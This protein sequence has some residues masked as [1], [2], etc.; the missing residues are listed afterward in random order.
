MLLPPTCPR[1]FVSARQRNKR[2]RK[3]LFESL[4]IRSLLAADLADTANFSSDLAA[5]SLHDGHSHDE[6]F[7]PPLITQY[8]Q[9]NLTGYL[10]GPASGTPVEIA[11]EYLRTH[12]DQLGATAADFAEVNVW[13][14]YVTETTGMT[15]LSIRQVLNGL[16]VAGTNFNVNVASD[17]RILNVGG[18]FVRDIARFETTAVTPHIDALK[19]AEQAAA[20]LDLSPTQLLT[21]IDDPTGEAQASVIAAAGISLA[22]IPASLEYVALSS[23]DVALTWKLTIQT[24]D[25][26]HWFDLSVSADDGRIASALDYASH[27]TYNVYPMPVES[28]QHGARATVTDPHIITPTPAPVPSPFGWHDTNGVAGAEFT[29]TRGNNVN[30]YTDTNNDNAADAGSQPDGGAGLDFNFPINLALEPDTF[31]PAAV[32][33]LFYWNNIIHDVTYLYGFNEAARNFQTNNYGRGGAGN[34]AVNAEAQDSGGFNNANFFTPPDGSQPRMQMYLGNNVSPKRDGSLDNAVIVHE[35]GHGISNRLTGNGSGLSATQSGGMGEGWSDWFSMMFTQTSAS[36]TTTAQGM[37]TYLFGQAVNGPGI[38]A[39]Q[40]DFDIVNTFNESFQAYGTGS[41]Q[42]T[43]VHWTGT[44]WASTLWD[45]NHLM[46]QK[47]GYEPNLYNS[48]STAGNVQTMHLVMNALKLQPLNPSL[49]QARDAVL[50]ADTTLNGGVNHGEIWTAFARRGLGQ[51]ASTASSNSTVLTTSFVIPPG[52]L[53]LSVLSTVPANNATVTTPPASYVV[54]VS[55]PL[56]PGT[57]DAADLQ[58]NGLPATGVAYTAGSLTATFT[59]AVNPVVAQG[60]QSITIAAGAFA[61]ASDSDLVDAYNGSFRYDVTPLTVTSTVPV[62]PGGILTIPGPV[63]FDVNFNETIA[64]GSVDVN[65][66]LLSEGT[67]TGAIALDADTARYTISGIVTEGPVTITV[68]D[69][70]LTDL[71]GNPNP[72]DFV[73]TYEADV[74]TLALPTPLVAEYPLGSLIYQVDQA[75]LIHVAGDID[76]FTLAVDPNQTLTVLVTPNSGGLRPTVELRDPS[77]AIVGTSSA[78]AA[79]QTA[80][81]QTIPTSGL[82][83]GT[84]TIAVSGVGTSIGNYTVS[85][86]LN[87]ALELEG[88]VTGAVNNSAATAQNLDASL[89]ALGT[90]ARPASRGAIRGMTDS[91]AGYSVSA[92]AFG[93]TDIS[94]TGTTILAN[95]DD[96][97]ATVSLPFTFNFYGTNYTQLFPSSN[98]LIAFGSATST[99]SNTSLAATPT[100]AAIAPFWDDLYLF[101]ATSDATLKSQVIGAVGSRQLILQWNKINFYSSTGGDTLT[102]QA[103]LSEGSNTIRFNYLDL[104]VS[105]E[106]RSEGTSA[107]VGIKAANPTGANFINIANPGPNAFVG[108]GKSVIIAPVVAGDDWYRITLAAG[109]RLSLAAEH[110]AIGNVDIQLRDPAGTAVLATGTTG[111]TNVNEA[112]RNFIAVSA[113]TYTVRVAGDSDIPYSL[114]VTKDAAFEL[115]G[116][117]A[118]ATAQ[119]LTGNAGVLGAV[120]AGAG[121][122]TL[123]ATDTGWITSVGAHTSTNNNYYVGYTAGTEYRNY[124][125]FSIP[126]TLSSIQS[127]ELRMLNPDYVSPDATETYSVFDVAAT[128]AALDTSRSSGDVTGISLFNDLGAGVQLASRTVS[129]ADE[130]T[131]VSIPLNAAGVAAV[132]AAIGS[133]L[134]VGGAI[135]TLLGTAEQSVFGFSSSSSTVQLMLQTVDPDWYRVTLSGGEVGFKVQTQTP[136]DGTG[137][138]S[139]LLN[140]KIRIY[141]SLGVEITPSVTILPDG[142]NEQVEVNNLSAGGTYYVQITAEAGTQGEYYVGLEMIAGTLT[143]VLNSGVLTVED[144]STTGRDNQFTVRVVNAGADLEISDANEAFL[145][146]PAGGVLSNQNRTLTIPLAGIN[147]LVVNG[148]AGDDT[149]VLES[150]GLLPSVLLDGGTGI[151]QFGTATQNIAPALFTSISISGTDPLVATSGDTFWLDV[152]GTTDPTLTI[153]GSAAPFLGLGSSTWSF[154]SGHQPIQVGSVEQNNIAGD[155]RAIFDNSIAPVANLVVMRDSALPAANLQLRDGSTAGPIIYQGTL[156]TLQSLQVLGTAGDDTVTIDDINGLPNLD[157]AVPGVSDNGNLTGTAALLFDGFGGQDTLTFRITGSAASQSYAI[158]NGSGAAGLQGEIQTVSAG[159]TLVAYFQNVELAERT[160][161]GPAAGDLKVLGDSS[162]NSIQTMASGLATRI[163][164]T[165]YT[166]FEFSGNNYN[167]LTIDALAGPDSIDLIN[168]GSDQS[169]HPTIQLFGGP[170]DDTLRVRS[171]SGNTGL[172]SLNGGAGND[173]FELFDAGDTVD[174]IAGPVDVDGFDGN[175]GGNL[176]TLTVVDRGDTDSDNV[177]FAPLNP[178]VSPDY[179]LNGINVAG[180]NDVVLRNIDTV[181]YTGTAA[182]DV[183]DVRLQNTIPL[184]DLSM[185]DFSGWTG[186]DLFLLFTSDQIGGSGPFSPNGIASGIA[187]IQLFGDAPGNPNPTDGRDNFGMPPSGI[188][189]TGAMDVGLAV[190]DTTRLIRPSASMSITIDGGRPTGLALPVGDVIGDVLNLD[191]GGLPN[192]TPVIVSTASPGTVVAAGI[193]PLTWTEIEDLNL[194]DQQKL[195][196]MQMGDLFARTTP[197][198]DLVQITQ[199]PTPLNPNQVR[200]RISAVIGNYSASNKTVVYGG[201]ANDSLTQAN[202]TIPAEFYGEDG[203]DYLT[204]ALNNDWLV[205]GLGHDRINGSGGD[206]VIWGDNAPTTPSDE[207]PQDEATGGNDA[208]SAAGGTD[209]FYGG[210]GNDTVSAGAGND[211][212]YGGQGHDTLDGNDGDDRLYGGLGNDIL[213]GH[214]GHDLLSGGEEDDKLFGATG[215]DTLLGG[216]GADVLA[217][218]EG[219]DLLVAGSVVNETSIWT[220]LG[221][222]ASYSAA[223]YTDPSGNDASLLILLAQWSSSNDRSALSAVVHDGANDDLSG[224]T[225]DDAFCWE[226]ADVLENFPGTAPPDFNAPFMGTDDRFGPT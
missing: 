183:I 170:A 218:G 40:Y 124:A 202:L 29:I 7:Q 95:V 130:G 167:G 51:L 181:H 180:G 103:V 43:A 102:F 18:G 45:L 16:D 136:A 107:T 105:G 208:L 6:P 33:N 47:Y 81:V 98:G 30:A 71:F 70:E 19:A 110:P 193:Q 80:L 42:Q 48:T 104:A 97:T 64:P 66:L 217:G 116:N 21:Y 23:T 133:S 131:N 15:H 2:S 59:F 197:G 135:T 65:D 123:A 226:L 72:L 186:A 195:T 26:D 137:E 200:L 117:N 216:A 63:T 222:T 88:N 68:K 224:D 86:I 122:T 39:Y 113:G 153:P 78:A 92:T 177:V 182:D 54:N 159:L 221:G 56:L 194:V 109:E 134:I 138:F 126:G 189:G 175:V 62:S 14:N 166:P 84:Y 49:V 34:D 142:R 139:N 96:S 204:G 10:T 111:A 4:E 94:T 169:N 79:G 184:H 192:S 154:A 90:P 223:T 187:S 206:N 125:T 129:A 8:D 35:Y 27:A 157:G 190:P 162:D 178:S 146:F 207:S 85:V 149:Y 172:V 76:Q 11:L 3:L 155:H 214:S 46:I 176:D 93:F 114:I 53:G 118:L 52:V 32:T 108:T 188:T 144:V 179:Y 37:G 127:A 24:P 12:A 50:L 205:G 36:D 20:Q 128:A 165:G 198:A 199:D 121:T 75:G 101:N 212:A 160:G 57:V 158:G 215:N 152:S 73:G 22:D 61:R 55:A 106:T 17:G 69:T 41:G 219:N 31:R 163:A 77:N 196:N 87:S 201:G 60:L 44:R 99:Y 91:A 225:G 74:A 213:S 203:D 28:P 58:V 100:Q 141:D 164:A 156:A 173:L 1:T 9:A 67:V 115:E 83:P 210:G 150:L 89:I 168:F 82:V 132:N 38:R 151:D 148:M 211:Y 112:I 185:V 13:T 209:V 120:V 147:S 191:I 174:N 25:G 145:S 119:D 5:N 143:A 171:T 140:P 220:S 161:S